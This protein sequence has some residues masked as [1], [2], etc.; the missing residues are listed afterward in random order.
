MVRIAYT[1]E[2]GMEPP[3]AARPGDAGVDLRISHDVFLYPRERVFAH[4]GLNIAIPEGYAGFVVPRSGLAYN[5]GVTVVNGP[6]LIDPGF[7]GEV[8]IIL[9][10]HGHANVEFRRG[11][12][13]AQLVIVPVVQPNFVLVDDLTAS[14]RGENGFGSTGLR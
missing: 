1:L 11:D 3:R 2:A 8:K 5:Y 13:V 9:I 10:N 6:G 12:R 7:R 4:T 14:D